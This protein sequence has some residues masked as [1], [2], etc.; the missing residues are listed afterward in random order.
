MDGTRSEAQNQ[1][2]GPV[3]PGGPFQLLIGEELV[4]DDGLNRHSERSGSYEGADGVEETFIYHT[5]NVQ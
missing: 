4:Y 2:R 3:S 1:D 5:Y